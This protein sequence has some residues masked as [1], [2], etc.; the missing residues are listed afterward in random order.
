MIDFVK[1][2]ALGND[3]ILVEGAVAAAETP[4]VAEP[5]V[6]RIIDYPLVIDG[7]ELR[8]TAC[9]TGNPH[10]SLFVERIDDAI[11][12]RIGSRLEWHPAFPNRT[13]VEFIRVMSE[14]E[15][16]VA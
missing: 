14:T 7:D 6:D 15:I 11:V 1:T 5:G 12:D 9:S 10:C 2:Q 4:F 8:I 16:E 13:N 3:F